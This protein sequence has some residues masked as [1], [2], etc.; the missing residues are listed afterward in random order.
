MKKRIAVIG[1]GISGLTCAYELQRAG[2]QVTVFEKENFV[3]GRMST[4]IKDDLPFDIGADHLGNAYTEMQRYCNELGIAWVPMIDPKYAILR[5]GEL[6]PAY[7]SVGKISQLRLALYAWLI[8]ENTDLFN[9]STA[10]KYDTESAYDYLARIAGKESAD[11]LAEGMTLGYQFHS[12]KEA[13]KGSFVAYM[14]SIKFHDWSLHKTQG[15][16]I[17]LSQAFADK[18]DIRLGN[19]VIEVVQGDQV[20]VTTAKGVETYDLA[21]LASTANMTKQILGD[22][23]ALQRDVLENTKYSTTISL[24]YKID[25]DKLVCE[26]NVF[27]PKIE[28]ST[29]ASYTNQKMKGD[30]WVHNGKSLLCAW[31]QPEFAKSIFDLPDEEVLERCRHELKKVAPWLKTTD[32]LEPYML[33]RWT[34]AMPIFCQG[35]LT[36]VDNFLKKGQGMNNIFLCGDY[37]NAPWTE[38]ALR[39]GQ[40][41]AREIVEKFLD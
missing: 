31:L 32:D 34:H 3:G 39:C 16:M 2:H 8:R 1:A 9:L 28:T 38:G 29:I 19:A 30:E 23:T 35:H 40:R 10:V 14:Q 5:K 20:T 4:R 6:L 11:Y 41:V 27:T 13:S 24:A 17:A 33:Y 18:L 12:S 25:I 7:K 37:L 22:Q 36:R 21:V 26:T 15:G